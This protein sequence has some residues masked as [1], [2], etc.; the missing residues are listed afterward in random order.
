VAKRSEKSTNPDYNPNSTLLSTYGA[1]NRTAFLLGHAQLKQNESGDY[2]LTDTYKVDTSESY[3]PFRDKHWDI[4][5]GGKKA[6]RAY[7]IAKFL[8]ITGDYKFNVPIK[9]EKLKIK[10]NKPTIED[11]LQ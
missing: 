5:E 6:S 2:T 4:S 8:G 11:I 9:A 7:D 1:S 10:K 3:K